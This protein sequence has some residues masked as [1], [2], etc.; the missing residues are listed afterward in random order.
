MSLKSK[1]LDAL[2]QQLNAEAA[3]SY[4]YFSMAA[5]FES[6]NFPGMAKWMHV[7]GQ[8]EW[9][10][11]MKFY[12]QIVDRGGRVT[13][14]QIDAPQTEWKSVLDAFQDAY[15]HE[16]EVTGLIHGLVK[17]AAAESDYATGAFLQWF[18]NEQVEEEAQVQFIVQRLKMMG[19]GNIGLVILDG[20]LG[21]RAG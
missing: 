1:V 17:L 10:H 13:L 21:K 15:A 19:D 16:C 3:S 7:Q 18:V 2:N 8:E 14:K 6:Q 20:E 5:F 12:R 4:L 11:A 9:G